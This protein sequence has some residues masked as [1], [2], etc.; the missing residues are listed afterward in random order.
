MSS[1]TF[2]YIYIF[3]RFLGNATRKFTWV[4]DLDE[5]L[6][7]D[8]SLHSEIQLFTLITSLDVSSSVL[9][10]SCTA[11]LGEVSSAHHV[12]CFMKF[13]SAIQKLNKGGYT[14]RHRETHTDSTVII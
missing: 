10:H 13:G 14:Y 8:H 7:D 1:D 3:P 6:F 5:Y 9:Q 11:N 12:S 2:I 4:S